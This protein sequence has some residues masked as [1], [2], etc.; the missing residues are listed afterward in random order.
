[1]HCTGESQQSRPVK[2]PETSPSLCRNY[3]P[4]SGINPTISDT[5]TKD[6][7]RWPRR[8]Y[9]VMKC[10]LIKLFVWDICRID[11]CSKPRSLL[12]QVILNE[13]AF[14]S[15]LSLP[16]WINHTVVKQDA[17]F[18][19]YNLSKKHKSLKLEAWE[20]ICTVVMSINFYLK[21]I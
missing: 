10:S 16:F 19:T 17:H 2:V 11:T 12:L 14:I 18:C 6:S 3:Q 8:V 4:Q 9:R 1:M 5:K 20:I 13:P 21:R 7:K 15:S